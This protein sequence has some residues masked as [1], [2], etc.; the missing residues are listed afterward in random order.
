MIFR[1]TKCDFEEEFSFQVKKNT[2]CIG[3]Q[4]GLNER[5]EKALD[6]D[7]I[8][9]PGQKVKNQTYLVNKFINYK[10]TKMNESS[11]TISQQLKYSQKRSSIIDRVLFS[12]NC[13]S[14]M[15]F[16]IITR[17]TRSPTIG[18]KFSSRHGQ[19]GVCGLVVKQEDLP[20]SDKGIS[21]DLI[22]N[23]HGFPS[24]MTVGKMIELISGK[25][26]VHKGFFSDATAFRK[27]NPKF[28]CKKLV[29]HGFNYSG[30][31]YLTSE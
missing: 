28:F 20:F 1:T 19:K 12:Q 5:F 17:D 10:T 25:V 14:S 21:P 15:F 7:G 26:A 16:K 4:G 3:P 23:P 30:K 22:M 18:D 11:K 27:V 31:D 24:R 9:L 13:N 6:H 2:F 8:C 29:E